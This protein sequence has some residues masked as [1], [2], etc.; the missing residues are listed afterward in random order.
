MATMEGA[1]DPA[2]IKKIVDNLFVFVQESVKVL[3]LAFEQRTQTLKARREV[4]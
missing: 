3:I 2:W 1:A 4:G